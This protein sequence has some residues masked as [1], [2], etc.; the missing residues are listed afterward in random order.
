MTPEDCRDGHNVAALKLLWMMLG[1]PMGY[2]RLRYDDEDGLP[3]YSFYGSHPVRG[4]GWG[5]R[6]F[7]AVALGLGEKYETRV[8]LAPAAVPVVGDPRWLDCHALW[9]VV[10]TGDGVQRLARFRTRPT[11]VLGEGDT[12]VR[13]AIW[14]LSKPLKWPWTVQANKRLAHHLGGPKKFS[15]PDHSI[16]VPGSFVR[17]GRIVPLPIHVLEMN[18]TGLYTAAEVV[19]YLPDAPDPNAWRERSAA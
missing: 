11:L 9:A 13:A 4:A 18:P 3:Q 8:G 6:R 17:D 5:E 14:A 16:R 15:D 19:K 1:G 12:R 2:L 10:D 7:V